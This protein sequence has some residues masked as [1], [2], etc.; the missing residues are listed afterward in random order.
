[1][2]FT[3]KNPEIF[4]RSLHS[5]GFYTFSCYI[6]SGATRAK[7]LKNLFLNQKSLGLAS[8]IV[9]GIILLI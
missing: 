4:L 2:S 7:H 9:T 8:A 3:G 6:Y 5:L 1:M